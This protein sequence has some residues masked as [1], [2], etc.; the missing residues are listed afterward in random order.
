MSCIV[1]WP[2]PHVYRN[3]FY[4]LGIRAGLLINEFKMANS[5]HGGQG[6][7]TFFTWARCDS[8]PPCLGRVK[9]KLFKRD[10]MSNPC[11]GIRHLVFPKA[12]L[13]LFSEKGRW[14]GAMKLDPSRKMFFH[15]LL[16]M[17]VPP[18]LWLKYMYSMNFPYTFLSQL[19]LR[20]W[21]SQSCYSYGVIWVPTES[22]AQNEVW[23]PYAV[24]I[25]SSGVYSVI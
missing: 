20:S 22:L 21:S 17:R 2:Q 25:Q 23:T 13:D 8:A 14:G 6:L 7:P 24:A 3:G 11:T 5:P 15:R 12:I 16:V 4:R 10:H 18:A 9:L 1:G 19:V